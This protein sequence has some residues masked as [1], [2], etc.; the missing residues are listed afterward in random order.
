MFFCEKNKINI[1]LNRKI[2][3][4]KKVIDA[5]K[6]PFFVLIRENMPDY[7][8]SPKKILIYIIER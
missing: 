2:F 1:S 8:V 5:K 4:Q 3:L 7:S 6:W